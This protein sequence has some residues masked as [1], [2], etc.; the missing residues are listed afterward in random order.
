[1]ENQENNNANLVNEIYDYAANLLVNKN[2]NAEDVKKALIDKGVDDKSSSIVVD[3]L[4]Q[5]INDSKKEQAKKDMIYGAMWCVGGVILTVAQVGF[6][7]WGAILFGGYQ[8]IKGV[9]NSL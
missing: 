5:Q 2:M 8:F 6:I 9:V 1:M 7:F 4:T 3:N